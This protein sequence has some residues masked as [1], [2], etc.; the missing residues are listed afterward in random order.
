MESEAELQE[1]VQTNIEVM[2]DSDLVPEVEAL[3]KDMDAIEQEVLEHSH[4]TQQQK[5]QVTCFIL[6]LTC[7]GALN[8]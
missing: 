8:T 7:F 3:Q 6:K 4:S 5:S 2:D 1:D